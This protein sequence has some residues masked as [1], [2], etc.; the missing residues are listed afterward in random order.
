MHATTRRGFKPRSPLRVIVADDV[1]E[2]QVLVETWLHDI[3]C[4]VKC[5][6]SGNEV[7]KLL[8][9]QHFDLV[10]A[11]VLMPDGDGLDV[12]VE[13]RHMQRKTPVLAISG[14]GRHL[15]ADQCLKMAHGLGA[16]EVLLKPFSREQLLSAVRRVTQEGN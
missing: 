11:D 13:L 6:S 12:I 8:R 3:G 5:A 16:N 14:G 1:P 7:F 4:E 15:E 10:I 9:Q 2:I